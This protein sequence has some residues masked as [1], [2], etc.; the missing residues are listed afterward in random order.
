MKKMCIKKSFVLSLFVVGLKLVLSGQLPA[1]TFKTLHNFN[2]SDGGNTLSGL[3]LSS[4]TL[5]GTTVSTVFALNSGGTG[6]RTLHTLNGGTE[7][8]AVLAG[9]VLSGNTLYGTAEVGGSSVSGYLGTV[10]AVNTDGT[11]FTSLHGFSNTDGNGPNC[12]LLLDGSTLYGVTPAGGDLGGKHYGNGTVF[13]I[14]TDGSGFINLYDLSGWSDGYQPY[15]GL[16][17]SNNT[18]YGTTDEGGTFG[19]GPLRTLF[20]NGTVF[21]IN[22]DGTGFT[23]LYSFTPPNT[24]SLGVY[25]NSDGFEPFAGLVLSGGSFY[26]TTWQGGIFGSGTIFGLQADGSAFTNL[27]N[28][29]ALPASGPKT[30][31]GGAQP[32]AVLRISGRT[33]YGTTSLGGD[34]G[35]GT[36]FAINTDGTGFTTLYSFKSADNGQVRRSPLL[37]SGNTLYGTT[38]GNQGTSYGTVF[39]ISFEPRLSIVPSGPNLTLTWPTSY[40]GFDYAGFT[41]QS[42]T[43]LNSPVWTTNLAGPVVI[44]G[45]FAVTNSISGTQ[46]F[47][48]LA[49]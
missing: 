39:S 48:R 19:T 12:D 4:N 22:T 6:F 29:P 13:A 18:L 49:Q 10:F 42:T 15:A 45:Q 5:Y 7:G 25:T 35:N 27:Y 46:Q 3:I 11:G 31:N 21:A 44:N 8:S 32:R 16:V 40:A 41:L 30:N 20:G 9:L 24:N 2:S 23:T 17:L 26:G 28:F 43:N 33:L 37:L 1:Q 36:I 14:N 47:F 34:F 38:A